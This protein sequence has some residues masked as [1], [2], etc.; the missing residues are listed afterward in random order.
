MI[1][2]A[3][4]MPDNLVYPDEDQDKYRVDWPITY[5]NECAIIEQGRI[6]YCKEWV[7]L[8]VPLYIWDEYCG[9]DSDE[10]TFT[11]VPR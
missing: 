5:D 11:L 4:A 1:Y 10:L 2:I 9:M 7:R 6:D 8:N 3:I